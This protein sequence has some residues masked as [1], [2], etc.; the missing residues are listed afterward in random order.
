LRVITEIKALR[1]DL[2]V[3]QSQLA[4]LINVKPGA[5]F[6]VDAS[7]HATPPRVKASVDKLVNLAILNRPE[8][9]EIS[10]EIR[11]IDLERK[12]DALELLPSIRPY[13]SSSVSSNDLLVNQSW[14]SAG[15]RISWDLMRLFSGDRRTKYYN[16]REALLDAR[17]LALTQAVATQVYVANTRFNLIRD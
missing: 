11:N 2:S 1:R 9:R 6:E 12:A 16:N 15:T 10:Y 7:G 17:A 13:I 8:L 5:R 3:A 14:V 4:A